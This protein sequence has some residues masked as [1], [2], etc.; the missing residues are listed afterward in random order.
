M[1]TLALSTGLLTMAERGHFRNKE[2]A[3]TLRNFS[4]MR[5]GKVT[6]TDIDGFVEFGDKAFVVVE[7]KYKD[8]PI[9]YGQG[10]AL[11]RLCDAISEPRKTLLVICSHDAAVGQEIDLATCQ[12]TRYKSQGRWRDGPTGLTVK[13]LIDKFRKHCGIE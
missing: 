13:A 5:W 3:R 8:S 11:E 6:P 4:G 7:A 12:V 9:P 10:L 2:A 1:K